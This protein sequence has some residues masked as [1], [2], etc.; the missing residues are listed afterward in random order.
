MDNDICTDVSDLFNYLTGYSK[1]ANFKKLIVAPISM[2]EQIISKIQREIENVKNGGK[3]QLIFKMNALVDPAVICALYDASENGVKIDLIIR[4]ICCLVPGVTSLSKNIKVTS[5]VGRFLEHS[6]IYYFYNNGDEEIYLSSA[7]MMQRNLD[8]RVEI[9]FPITNETLKK[10]LK[11]TVIKHS[12][13]DNTKA[14][15]LNSDMTY[16]FGKNGKDD[17][18]KGNCQ[19]WLMEHSEKLSTKSG[20]A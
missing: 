18:V 13:D 20:K 12:L 15:I 14:R 7:D 5:I 17:N 4:G 3:G 16:H 2:R 8:R 6:R 1:Q 19:Q 10:E 9:A 11:E